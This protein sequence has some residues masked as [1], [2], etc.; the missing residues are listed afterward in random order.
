MTTGVASR[1]RS[2]QAHSRTLRRRGALILAPFALLW[3]VVAASGLPGGAAWAVRIGAVVLAGAAIAVTFRSGRDGTPERTRHQPDGWYRWVGLVNL[4]QFVVIA[5]IVAVGI[6]LTVPQ[7]VPPAVCLVVGLHF[8]PLARLF[9][10]PQY[11]WT[12]AGL[13]VAAGAGLLVLAVAP[14]QEVSRVV[15]GVLAAGTL[16]ATAWH[17]ALRR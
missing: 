5:L 4:A 13:C 6:A 1:P 3:A 16:L 2:P 9:D 12:G 15:I 7:L 11:T 10:Q 8:F 17:L 14:S